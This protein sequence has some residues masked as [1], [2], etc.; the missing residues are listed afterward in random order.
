[1]PIKVQKKDYATIFIGLGGTG[2][3]AILQIKDKFRERL[4]CDETTHNPRRTAFLVLD[5]DPSSCGIGKPIEESEYINIDVAGLQSILRP[6]LIPAQPTY[7]RTWLNPDLTPAA[8]RIGAGGIRQIG[9]FQLFQHVND[10]KTK[11]YAAVNSTTKADADAAASLRQV[12]IVI[13]AGLCGGTGAG[14]FMDAAY[15][16]QQWSQELFGGSNFQVKT[17]GYL[18]MP[19]VYESEGR[20]DS[21]P[22]LNLMKAGAY[23]ALKE[24]DYWMSPGEKMEY[25]QEY[26][27]GII[28]NWKKLGRPFDITFLMSDTRQNGTSINKP[29]STNLDK[30]AEMLL[31]CYAD[32]T[33]NNFTFDSFMANVSTSLQDIAVGPTRDIPVNYTF[34]SLGVSTTESVDELVTNFEVIKTM[35]RVV[36]VPFVDDQNNLCAPDA[37]PDS[38]I[39]MQSVP[40]PFYEDIEN[41]HD[42]YRQLFGDKLVFPGN[43]KTE[44]EAF[45]TWMDRELTA[46]K[47]TNAYNNPLDPSL[48]D[49]KAATGASSLFNGS[50]MQSVGTIEQQGSW[51]FKAQNAANH[52]YITEK[53]NFDNIVKAAIQDIVIGPVSLLSMLN[54]YMIPRLEN[55]VE[56]LDGDAASTVT[57]AQRAESSAKAL[58]D[59][60]ANMGTLEWLGAKAFPGKIIDEYKNYERSAVESQRAYCYYSRRLAHMKKFRDD[61][62]T[63]AERL[64]YLLDSLQA[65]SAESAEKLETVETRLISLDK[66]QD[67]FNQHQD[68]QDRA[69]AQ[70]RSD[71]WHHLAEASVEAA[72]EDIAHTE[73]ERIENQSRLRRTVKTFLETITNTLQLNNLDWIVSTLQP[74]PAE[75]T[76]Y[77]ATNFCARLSDVAEPMLPEIAASSMA[78]QLAIMHNY[79]SVPKTAQTMVSGFRLYEQNHSKTAKVKESDIADRVLWL[80]ARIGISAATVMDIR[81]LQ[82][83]YEQRLNSVAELKAGLHLVDSYPAVNLSDNAQWEPNRSW[84]LLPNL[85]PDELFPNTD[86]ITDR[87]KANWA[88]AKSIFASAVEAQ[89]VNYDEIKMTFALRHMA[90]EMHQDVFKQKVDAIKNDIALTYEERLQKLD[91]MWAGMMTNSAPISYRQYETRMRGLQNI[92][93][94]LSGA[95]P[96]ETALYES[97]CLQSRQELCAYLLMQHPHLLRKLQTQM[98]NMEYYNSVRAYLKAEWDKVLDADKQ[99]S[100][101]AR[102][103]VLDKIT[104][105]TGKFLLA[106]EDFD[107]NASELELFSFDLEKMGFTDITDREL[108][109]GIRRYTEACFMLQYANVKN[110]IPHHI[111]VQLDHMLQSVDGDTLTFKRRSPKL[112]EEYKQA[113]NAKLKIYEQHIGTARRPSDIE[114]DPALSFA[115]AFIR[116]ELRRPYKAMYDLLLKDDDAISME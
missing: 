92:I 100:Q 98:T 11:F 30:I 7:V 63:Y 40:H 58:S 53:S 69:L 94:P 18:M 113:F 48:D 96:A 99:F 77:V 89:A 81:P 68:E 110:E 34:A 95:S 4:I 107:G 76:N 82:E 79:I 37:Q 103:M 8:I 25:T 70:T 36:E 114:T 106:N 10:F 3:D 84:A 28:A 43:L 38:P 35:E 6:D 75:Q 90:D 46:F 31:Y 44:D 112:F 88:K 50:V 15:L 59:R 19:G 41:R 71:I 60:L 101:F 78:P 55:I 26:G 17:Y 52:L 45:K 62:K 61:V 57:A 105:N 27:N 116:S 21:E 109:A 5:G 54:T 74:D 22:K 67:Y 85:L 87:A 33:G 24:L 102:L 1:M 66:L 51:M 49:I 80:N 47:D 91:D 20:Y 16:V 64:Q 29:Y 13:C 14:T 111:A 108:R 73:V 2:K 56:K 83:L 93:A 86:N 104:F 65:I 39:G 72:K 32:E 115:P 9:R 97:K 42:M 12:D 23:A